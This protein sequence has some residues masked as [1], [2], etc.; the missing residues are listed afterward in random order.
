MRVRDRLAELFTDEPFATG[1]GSRGRP[2]LP[3][4]A[5]S[6]VTVL[7]FAENLTDRQAAVRAARAIHWKYTL[8]RE[9]T[10]P[11]FDHTASRASGSGWWSMAGSGCCSTVCCTTASRRAWWPPVAHNVPTRPR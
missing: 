10:E 6:L 2:G 5:L 8:G 4:G 1:Y 9:L 7:Q 11:G 3:P